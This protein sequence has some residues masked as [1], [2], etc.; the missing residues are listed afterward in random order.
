MNHAELYSHRIARGWTDDQMAVYLGVE[1]PT[2]R[3]WEKNRRGVPDTVARLVY[4]LS[5]VE[6]LAP[7]I[8]RQLLAP[9]PKAARKAP[10]RP[11]KEE[12]T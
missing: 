9:P 11:A 1:L 8:H 6:T 12:A 3:N 10:G 4:V 2:Y 5:L 7:D